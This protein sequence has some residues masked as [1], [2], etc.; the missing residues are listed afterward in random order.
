MLTSV[1]ELLTVF[2]VFRKRVAYETLA[3]DICNVATVFF[4]LIMFC[5]SIGLLI[6]M[7]GLVPEGPWLILVS[8]PA[9]L[10]RL[11]VDNF[12]CRQHFFACGATAIVIP[13]A[14]PAYGLKYHIECLWIL[15]SRYLN[16]GATNRLHL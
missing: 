2:L 8:L 16:Q 1:T 15:P 10:L 3:S 6:I 5:V 4:T 13:A 9:A 12:R 7:T 11:G 14:Q